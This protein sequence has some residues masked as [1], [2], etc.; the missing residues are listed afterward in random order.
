LI[1]C[2]DLLPED[3]RLTVRRRSRKRPLTE[4]AS[5][6]P[7]HAFAAWLLRAALT[8]LMFLALYWM[9]ANVAVPALTNSFLDQMNRQ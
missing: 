6:S 4:F 7:L 9:I 2:A 8:A 5:R 3:Q 1:A